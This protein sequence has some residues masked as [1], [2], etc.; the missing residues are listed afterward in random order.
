MNKVKLKTKILVAF[1]A[2]S[3]VLAIGGGVGIFF[4]HKSARAGTAMYENNLKALN[5]IS[6]VLN[7]FMQLRVRSLYLQ[8]EK[9]VMKDDSR[10]VTSAGAMKEMDKKMMSLVGE[11]EKRVEEQNKS[12]YGDFKTQLTKYIEVRSKMED[13]IIAGNQAEAMDYMV[14]TVTPQG[15]K[16]LQMFD[17]LYE[18][19]LKNAQAKAENNNSLTS[20]ASWFMG[21]S[22]AGGVAFF[23]LL[24]FI[25][26]RAI[27]LPIN[28]VVTGMSEGAEQVA[29]AS[30]QV[31]SASQS[32]AEGAS[33]QASALEETSAS[34]EELSS[35]TQRTLD[36]ADTLNKSGD[37]TFGL[38]KSTHKAL[39]E[40]D[41]SMK[42][43]GESS[44][45]ASKVV[46]ASDEIAF[47][48]NLLALN[49]AVEAARAGEAGSGF[50]V[51]A[52]EVRN[53]A[54]KS[55]EA[56]KNTETIIGEMSTLIDDGMSLVNKT[57]Q[58]FYA[59]GDEGK[60]TNSMIK[61][62]HQAAQEQ[63]QGIQQIATAVG[64]MDKVTQ[65]TAA[66]A[67]ES[68]SAAEELNA[69]AQQMKAF[70]GDLIA[71]IGGVNGQTGAVVR[72]A[73]HKHP[74]NLLQKRTIAP[75]SRPIA[76]K[77]AKEVRPDQLI[78]LEEKDFQDF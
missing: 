50:A 22:T 51:V 21:L 53:L 60:K 58:S 3:M 12:F 13:I 26:V 19:E 42:R 38:M 11:Y 78:P 46:K 14:G 63:M 32:L 73:P 9:F 66:S 65:S 57:L 59:M 35:M 8:V 64:S 6:K 69:Q 30:T 33:E 56:A 71:V 2:V 43:I 7:Y 52:E 68:A 39:K 24:G 44:E 74:G 49:A 76:G 18:T 36:N 70:V 45:K 27:T 48:I 5:D 77:G 15:A 54:K 75:V 23:I 47:Q 72:S 34:L 28:R 25:L 4:L 17:Q 31:A 62:I 29:S 10:A 55:A 1:V 37:I 16:L 67:E 61:E 40:T 20:W 41:T